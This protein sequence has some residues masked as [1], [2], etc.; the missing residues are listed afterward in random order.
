MKEMI[1]TQETLIRF[2]EFLIKEEKEQATVEKYLR[3]VRAFAEYTGKKGINKDTVL[4]YKADLTEKNYA[5]RSIN[6]MLVAI[7]KLLDFLRLG[8]CKVKLMKIQKEVFCPEHKELTREEYIRLCRVAQ[9]SNRE[10]LY[11]IL[12]TLAGTGI[13]ISELPYI[14]VDAVRKGEAVVFL[15][16]KTRSILIVRALQ[17]KLLRYI[18]QQNIK[19]GAVFVTRSG[20]AMS[21]TNIWREM[22]KLCTDAGVNPGKVFPHNLRHLF[23]RVF[24]NLEKD[25]AK[26]S[27]LLGH[28]SIETTRIYIISSGKEHRRVLENM[29]LVS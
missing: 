22:K 16:G 28:S 14:T 4:A 12:Q 17:E 1:I 3:D 26:L 10:R 5:A 25:I 6:S 9:T 7:H 21:R 2:K 8:E 20:K 18:A 15:K 19:E 27:D 29:K 13:R 24:Y 11:M 23:A